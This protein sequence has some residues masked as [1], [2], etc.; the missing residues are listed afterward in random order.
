MFRLINILSLDVAFGATAF[1][2]LAASFFQH[3]ISPLLYFVLFVVVWLIYT[4]DHLLDARNSDINLAYRYIFHQKNFKV[5]ALLSL[6]FFCVLLVLLFFLDSYIIYWSFLPASLV[7]LHFFLTHYVTKINEYIFFPKEF[8]VII[9]FTIGVLLP[10][11]QTFFLSFTSIIFVF[12]IFLILSINSLLLSFFE[13][14]KDLK[15]NH[16]TII[17][18]LGLSGLSNLILICF[19]LA[20]VQIL[21][22]FFLNG[23]YFS[24]IFFVIMSSYFVLF[25]FHS[26]FR[27]DER[28]RMIV[29]VVLCIPYILVF[30]AQ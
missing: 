1:A 16:K 20:F 4:L 23:P 5:L 26:F 30:I 18:N 13:A 22:L 6:V 11:F 14:K 27:I 2:Y 25:K 28:Y 7:I 3:I 21:I 15:A 24:S 29:D 12:L 8:T 17:T 10:S 9:V 19:V